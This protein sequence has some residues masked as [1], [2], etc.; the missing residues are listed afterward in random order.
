MSF[1][2]LTESQLV[3]P[4]IVKSP[5]DTKPKKQRQDDLPG[6]DG[7]QDENKAISQD[8]ERASRLFQILSAR[9]D[10]DHPVCVECTEML[11]AELQ[12]RLE[13][14]TKERDAYV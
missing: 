13:S 5:E 11:V 14:A 9:S 1:V 3:P 10:I 12:R 2:M 7:A 4:S 6:L 8:M